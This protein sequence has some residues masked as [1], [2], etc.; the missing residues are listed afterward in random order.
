MRWGVLA[1]SKVLDTV[2]VSLRD[3]SLGLRKEASLIVY[4]HPQLK[5]SRGK[6]SRRDKPPGDSS[7]SLQDD[8][9]LGD[10]VAFLRYFLHGVLAYAAPE[11]WHGVLEGTRSAGFC[12]SFEVWF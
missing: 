12:P 6:E 5:K 7:A 3:L 9:V 4:K 8:S 1:D 2:A 11:K 10:L